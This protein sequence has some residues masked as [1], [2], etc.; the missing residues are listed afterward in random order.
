[1]TSAV[2]DADIRV[3]YCPEFPCTP[4][5]PF[6]SQDS[7]LPSKRVP[8]SWSSCFPAT[9]VA[10]DDFNDEHDGE[11]ELNDGSCPLGCWSCSFESQ[12]EVA[13]S[14]AVIPHPPVQATSHASDA[15]AAALSP[16]VSAF[17]AAVQKAQGQR[18]PSRGGRVERRRSG[19]RARAVVAAEAA[20]QRA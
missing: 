11:A 2:G 16:A 13:D 20:R 4:T 19:K 6:S 8:L 7:S 9:A 5:P 15:P 1:M 12:E 3:G 14:K 17:F 18:V 10:G